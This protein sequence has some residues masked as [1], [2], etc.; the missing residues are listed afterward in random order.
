MPLKKG[1]CFK[2]DP[3]SRNNPH[4][5]IVLCDPNASGEIAVVNF[6]TPCG[7]VKAHL[8]TKT[9]FPTLQYDSELAWFESLVLDSASV[10]AEIAGGVFTRCDGLP[11]SK[12]DVLIL[13]AKTQ[14]L[15]P[16]HIKSF[17]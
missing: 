2:G 5:W 10:E 12:V 16:G 17:V 4:Y 9:F 7:G 3:A 11:V 15:V 1:D 13:I 14:K 6:T 8:V